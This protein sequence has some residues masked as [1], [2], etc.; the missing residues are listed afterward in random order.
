M[1]MQC[2]LEGVKPCLHTRERTTLS[3]QMQYLAC[4]RTGS[5]T[6]YLDLPYDMTTQELVAP[7][8]SSFFCRCKMG[9]ILL[10]MDRILRPEGSIIFRDDVDLLVKIKSIIDGMQ[11]D[12]RIVDHEKGPHQREKILW[13]S[14]LYWTAAEEKDGET[15]ANS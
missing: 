12:A 10:E 14:K 11:Y 6:V 2:F 15:R 3:M 1:Q 13:A 4:T 8:A 9:D 7:E 5:I